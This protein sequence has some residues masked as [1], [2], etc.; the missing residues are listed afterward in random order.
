MKTIQVRMFFSP[1]PQRANYYPHTA[2][3]GLDLEGEWDPE[4]HDQQMSGLYGTDDDVDVE[5]P[6]WDEDIDIE[7]IIPNHS[8]V[9]EP[10][11]KK[12]KKKKKQAERGEESDLGVDV[13]TMDADVE[14]PVDD[15]EWDGTEEMRKRKLDEY[16]DE[17]YGLDFNDMVCLRPIERRPHDTTHLSRLEI[18]PHDLNMC[19]CQRKTSH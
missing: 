10:N 12:K 14:K 3:Q 13:D 1:C 15:E 5:K 6:Q 17:I 4:A 7:D 2:L 9:S 18:Y 19:L 11:A 16:M 8:E